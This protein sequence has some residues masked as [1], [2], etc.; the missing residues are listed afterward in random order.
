MVETQELTSKKLKLAIDGNSVDWF[1]QSLVST[2]NKTDLEIGITLVVGGS[3]VSGRLVGGK[4]YF[5]I[6]AKEFSAMWPEGS[7]DAIYQAFAKYG[8]IYSQEENHKEDGPPPQFIHLVDSRCFFPGNQ[9]P[10]NKGV[11]WR[12]RIN[13][14]SGFSLGQLSTAQA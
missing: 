4:R 5:E 1:L 10:D 12:G 14:V 6:F 2:V 9:L 7:S 13:S 8:E 3:I 11:L